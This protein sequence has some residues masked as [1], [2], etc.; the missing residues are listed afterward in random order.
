M[1]SPQALRAEIATPAAP[2]FVWDDPFRFEDQLSEDE[3]ADPARPP[4]PTLRNS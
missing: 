3:R 2:V 1:S 4:A